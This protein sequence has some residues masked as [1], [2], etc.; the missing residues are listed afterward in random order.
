MG[1]TLE[2]ELASSR[3]LAQAALE[4]R[5]HELKEEESDIADNRVRYDAE[6]LLEFYDELQDVKVA[7]EV[8]DIIKRFQEVEKSL[9]EATTTSL[10]L[11]MLPL[12]HTTH[13]TQYTNVIHTLDELGSECRELGAWVHSL[14]TTA[15]H[16]KRRLPSLLHNLTDIL[17][18]HL[19]NVI[20][21]R[22]V[23]QCCKEN[24]H[25]GME[26]LTLG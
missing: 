21:A 12:D 13:I 9:N 17:Q 24:Y 7:N 22:S 16:S 8:A 20:C 11:T 5:E 1:S 19:E 2:D 25:I 18:G 6:R 10:R 14:P 4:H 23:V 15:T 3:S 26:T